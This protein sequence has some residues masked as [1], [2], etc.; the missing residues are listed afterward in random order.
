MFRGSKLKNINFNHIKKDSQ[1]YSV[2]FASTSQWRKG[3][4]IFFIVFEIIA[5]I[6]IHCGT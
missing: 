2:A 5:S 4:V 6:R 3:L 1:S